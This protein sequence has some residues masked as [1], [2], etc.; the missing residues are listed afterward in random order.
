M[1]PPEQNLCIITK[2]LFIDG[3][4]VDVR[5]VI[6]CEKNKIPATLFHELKTVIIARAI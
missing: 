3:V 4:E 1:T 5:G 2:H 6:H